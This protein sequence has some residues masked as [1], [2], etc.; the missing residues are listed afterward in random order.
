MRSAS[1]VV[2]LAALAAA[3]PGAG[4]LSPSQIALTPE[5]AVELAVSRSPAFAAARAR[6]KADESAARAEGRP[7]NPRF[8]GDYKAGTGVGRT[9]INLTFDVWTLVGAGAR[10]RAGRRESARAE[11]A[12]AERLLALTADAKS[13]VYEVQAASATVLL[14]REQAD[15]AAAM[16]SLAAGQRRAGNIAQ[17]DLDMETAAAAQAAIDADRADADLQAARSRLARLLRVPVDAGWW[18]NAALPAPVDADPDPATLVARARERRPM[19]AAAFAAAE[20]ARAR[21]DGATKAQLGEARLGIAAEKET[22]GRR[23]AGPSMEMDLPVFGGVASKL[24]EADARAAEAEALAQDADAEVAAEVETLCARLA[25]AKRAAAR[26]AAEIVP[27]RA[28]IVAQAQLR[29]NGMLTGADRLLQARQAESDARRE[30]VS[31]LRD[32]WTTRAALERATG[33][34]L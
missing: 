15:A 12:L 3:Q 9:E 18:T 31:A 32:Y 21:A 14:R 11:A 19:R 8:T 16:A 30:A 10:R 24:D 29:Y 28:R 1:L 25:A 7:E 27:A 33:G 26:Y 34:P 2:F 17:L 23:L 22:D 5:T 20:V 4:Q 6:A 13:A